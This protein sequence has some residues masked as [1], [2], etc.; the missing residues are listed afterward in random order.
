MKE[1]PLTQGKVALIDDADFDLVNQY[2]W[3]AHYNRKNGACYAITNI[4]EGGKYRLLRMHVLLVGKGHDHKDRNGL[5]NQRENLRPATAAQNQAN[6][7]MYRN[8][9]SGYKGVFYKKDKR[10]WWAQIKFDGVAENLGYYDTA[11]EAAEAYNEAARR[12][13]GEFAVLN[14]LPI[15][16][17]AEGTDW[18]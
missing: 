2:K 5:N 1:I 16:G 17:I 14:V 3:C 4:R 6:H 8:N 12:I 15:Q 7:G 13:H 18:L 9:K 11:R 10:K